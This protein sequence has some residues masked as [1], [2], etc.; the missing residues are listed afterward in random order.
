[1]LLYDITNEKSFDNIR[2]WIRN[3]QDVSNGSDAYWNVV[4]H[5]CYCQIACQSVVCCSSMH[6]P[7]LNGWF[8]ATSATLRT[9]DKCPK[10]AVNKWVLFVKSWCWQAGQDSHLWLPIA[11]SLVAY[12]FIVYVVSIMW[13]YFTYCSL[14]LSMESNSWRR[15]LSRVRT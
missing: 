6:R 1:M 14:P 12:Y 9:G 11:I 3:I 5:I 4:W 2:N 13:L 8:W 7:T 15:V 10:P